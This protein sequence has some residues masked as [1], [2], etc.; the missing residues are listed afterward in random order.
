[1]SLGGRNPWTSGV[2]VVGGEHYFVRHDVLGVVVEVEE[3]MVDGFETLGDA[4]GNDLPVV[5]GDDAGQPVGGGGAVTLG[6]EVEG[7]GVEVDLAL[8]AAP[9]LGQAGGAEGSGGGG[10]VGV[11]GARL[12]VRVLPLAVTVGSRGRRI[13]GHQHPHGRVWARV[14]YSTK[15][16]GNRAVTG[17]GCGGIWPR[18]GGGGRG[19]F[20]GVREIRPYRRSASG[21]CGRP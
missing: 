12:S 16:D 8:G 11:V 13:E 3:E 2:E 9:P 20:F 14:D 19:R 17:P 5:G 10:D 18:A 1:M 7:E 15:G 4:G 21:T 6:V